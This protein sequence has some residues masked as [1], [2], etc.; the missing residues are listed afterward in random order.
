MKAK[1]LSLTCLK[2]TLRSGLQG[3]TWGA[4]RA[5]SC[6]GWKSSWEQQSCSGVPDA[7]QSSTS[8][9][10][11]SPKTLKASF[12][13][14]GLCVVPCRGCQ[15]KIPSLCSHKRQRT[16]AIFE[17]ALFCWPNGNKK[18]KPKTSPSIP[19]LIFAWASA[20]CWNS[21]GKPFLEVNYFLIFSEKEDVDIEKRKCCREFRGCV[22]D[23]NVI[24]AFMY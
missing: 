2:W 10:F 16:C 23:G 18:P 22:T 24:A 14:K 7:V 4:E 9:C 11:L 15:L 12:W 3:E 19:Q 5:E 6:R 20:E 21:I 8:I 1:P 13:G 17:N